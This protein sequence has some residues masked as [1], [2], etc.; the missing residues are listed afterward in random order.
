M[1]DSHLRGLQTVFLGGSMENLNFGRVVL[2]GLLAGLVIVIGE[3]L[4]NEVLVG[5][6]MSAAIAALNLPPVAGHA[7]VYFLLLGFGLGIVAVWLYAA[8]RPRYGVGPKTAL[9][10]GLAVWSL[11]YAY[12][13]LGM[14]VMG[15]F[16][17]SIL[18]WGLLWG[19]IEIPLATIAGAWVYREEAFAGAV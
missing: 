9:C 13:S 3:F 12:P 18:Q 1:L 7:Y 11:A 14:M 10:A 16:P 5:Q 6:Q 2:G 17:T 4:F 8:S 19:L 15:L